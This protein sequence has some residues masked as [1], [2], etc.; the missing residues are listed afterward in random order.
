MTKGQKTS[1]SIVLLIIV[2]GFA[3]FLFIKKLNLPE[4]EPSINIEPIENTKFSNLKK[5]LEASTYFPNAKIASNEERDSLIIDDQYE[6]VIKTGYYQMTIKDSKQ[7]DTYCQIVDAIE[8][9]LGL[10][11]EKS[12]E[13]CKK[14]LEGSINI[15]GINAEIYD[16]YKVLSVNIDTPATLYNIDS[17][18]T[19][20]DVISIDKINY[21]IKIDNYLLT[22]L[23]SSYQSTTKLYSICGNIY[24]PSKKATDKFEISIYDNN[25]KEI[26]KKTY[27]YENNTKKYIPFCVDYPLDTDSAKYY[28]VTKMKEKK[29]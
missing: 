21:N 6:I 29:W 3:V 24:N 22:S 25:K 1:I 15:G 20:G 16:T 17:T 8:Q 11:A 9:G 5:F 7:E 13:T 18:H 19:S 14:T 28:S 26:A 27:K 4:R 23:Y 12:I 2:L 10:P